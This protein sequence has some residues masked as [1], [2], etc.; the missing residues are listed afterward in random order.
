ME[1]ARLSP[2]GQIILP[3]H[4]RTARGWTAGT[5]FFVEESA[6]G[7][8]LRP[9]GRLAPTTLEEVAGCLRTTGTAKTLQEMKD[10]V[11]REV[12]RRHD[13]GRF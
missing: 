4:I 9:V 13:R 1:T 6:A 2:K 3:K 12:K 11:R 10:A 7:V 8:L 5:E